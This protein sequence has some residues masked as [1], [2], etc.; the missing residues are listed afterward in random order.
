MRTLWN[1]DNAVFVHHTRWML[2]VRPKDGPL[3]YLRYTYLIK[4]YQSMWCTCLFMPLHRSYYNSNCCPIIC[5]LYKMYCGTSNLRPSVVETKVILIL[6]VVLIL[7]WSNSWGGIPRYHL[8]FPTCV[9][10]LVQ[11]FQI[12]GLWL[13]RG[14]CR[15]DKEKEEDRGSLYDGLSQLCQ[16]PAHIPE[17]SHGQGSEKGQVRKMWAPTH[18]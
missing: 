14:T 6:G 2:L 7:E 9:P 5:S 12:R 4:L 1:N 18:T 8:S 16:H 10:P 15:R 11:C 3:Y 13:H 17:R